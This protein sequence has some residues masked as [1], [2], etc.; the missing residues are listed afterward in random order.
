MDI[1][2]DVVQRVYLSVKNVQLE[3][4]AKENLTLYNPLLKMNDEKLFMLKSL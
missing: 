4:Y 1:Q 3:T 2:T